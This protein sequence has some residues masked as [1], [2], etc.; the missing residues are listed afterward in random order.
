M[1]ALDMLANNIANTSVAGFKI[2]RELYDLY[3]SSDASEEGTNLPV[4]QRNWIDFSQGVLDSTGSSLD[5]ALEGAGFFVTRSPSGPL[6]TRTGQLKLST[7]GELITQ[8]GYAIQGQDGKSIKVDSAQAIDI[9][10]EGVVH[11]SGEEVGRL[12]VVSFKDSS[13]LAKRGSTYFSSQASATAEPSNALVRQGRLEQANG[14]P[15]VNAVRLISVM[16]QFESLK[17]AL[18]VGLDM[19]RRAIEDVA[20]VS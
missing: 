6:Y 11:Q 1:E 18:S 3:R 15:G 8:E 14:E 4:I 17:K 5:L 9:D 10:T 20:K 16:R 19:N 7:E 13:V 12:A 2:D